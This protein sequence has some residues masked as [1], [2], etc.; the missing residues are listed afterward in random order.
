MKSINY[1]IPVKSEYLSIFFRQG[2]ILPKRFF[3][4]ESSNRDRNIDDNYFLI[5]Q[6]EDYFG[7]D[8]LIEVVLNPEEENQCNKHENIIDIFPFYKPLPITRIKGLIFKSQARQD[9]ITTS[10]SINTAFFPPISNFFKVKPSLVSSSKPFFQADNAEN[11]LENIKKFDKILGAFAV[12]KLSGESYMNYSE[13][14]FSNLSFFNEIIEQDAK[15]A[16]VFNFEKIYFSNLIFTKKIYPYINKEFGEEDII[17]LAN[18]DN[19]VVSKN[20]FSG[21]IEFDRLSGS[22]YILSI[23]FSYG[24]GDDGKGLKADSLLTSNFR[25]HIKEEFSEFIAFC[26][27]YYKGY[28]AFYKSYSLLDRVSN[29]KFKF[30]SK[31]DYYTVETIYQYA[32]NGVKKSSY[33]PYLDNWCPTLLNK[34]FKSKLNYRILDEVVSARRRPP[35]RSMDYLDNLL[36]DERILNI[37]QKYLREIASLMIEDF[38]NEMDEVLEEMQQF[39]STTEMTINNLKIIIDKNRNEII[40]LNNE[41]ESLKSIES[42]NAVSEPDLNFDNGVENESIEKEVILLSKQNMIMKQLLE[43]I[44]RRSRSSEIKDEIKKFFNP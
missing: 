25:S 17:K 43:S 29:L 4:S 16:N 27:G 1:F 14:Y 9:I 7:N 2:C 26:Y 8:C 40:S 30:D 35:I 28:F 18:E 44:F 6:K 23:L 39:R 20:K 22:P 42:V 24:I 34:V 12:M 38:N 31:L 13:N 37:F 33:F 15:R 10:I 36:R 41:L 32:F 11:Y 5:T 21:L 3:P 19:Q